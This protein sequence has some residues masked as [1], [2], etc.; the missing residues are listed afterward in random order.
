[1]LQKKLKFDHD[2]IELLAWIGLAIKNTEQKPE[3][4]LFSRRRP[5]S[6]RMFSSFAIQV[7]HLDVSRNLC[8]MTRTTRIYT[9]PPKTGAREESSYITREKE[10]NKRAYQ[11]YNKVGPRWL[12]FS[13]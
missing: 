7:M 2:Q 13:A 11:T 1:L 6:T 10:E 9:F 3:F 5:Q 4:C 8:G 12:Q